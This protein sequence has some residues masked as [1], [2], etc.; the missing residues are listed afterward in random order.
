VAQWIQVISE[1]KWVPAAPPGALPT[2]GASIVLRPCEVVLENDI[3]NSNMPTSRFPLG[4]IRVFKQLPP[5]IQSIFCWGT[6]KPPPPVSRLR[7]IVDDILVEIQNNRYDAI[8]GKIECTPQRYNELVN[9]WY[10][11]GLAK[12]EGRLSDGDT[13][14]VRTICQNKSNAGICL[15]PLPKRKEGKYNLVSFS[16]IIYSKPIEDKNI[17]LNTAIAKSLDEYMAAFSLARSGYLFDIRDHCNINPN[18]DSVNQFEPWELMGVGNSIN[19]II[20]LPDRITLETAILFLNDL[21]NRCKT[22]NT[23]NNTTSVYCPSNSKKKAY[24]FALWIIIKSFFAK[25]RA[26][27]SNP[28]NVVIAEAYKFLQTK[29]PFL[30]IYCKAGPKFPPLFEE[31]WI[32]WSS[33]SDSS[34]IIPVLFDDCFVSH[35]CGIAISTLLTKE[36]KCQPIGVL[37][38]CI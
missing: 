2:D 31:K 35:G 8:N 10:G 38:N 20:S 36:H 12:N 18:G 17:D 25:R 13:A 19:Q 23:S 27:M 7:S 11:I 30:M 32:S 16:H 9:I 5:K 34:G 26:D 3:V 4:A 22:H 15:M 6:V 29:V 37:D 14:I 24:S 21:C 28:S 1:A 33:Q